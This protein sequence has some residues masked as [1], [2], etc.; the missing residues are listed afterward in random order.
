MAFLL[1]FLRGFEYMVD[2]DINCSLIM[3]MLLRIE[4][5]GSLLHW[6]SVCFN[7]DL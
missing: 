7:F 3:K 6:P 4:E 2:Q 1:L 5:L